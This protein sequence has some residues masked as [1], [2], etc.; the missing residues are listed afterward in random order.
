MGWLL[1][2]GGEF[3][4][5]LANKLLERVLLQGDMLDS[6]EGKVFTLIWKSPALS[7]VVAFP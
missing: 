1:E 6:L 5:K 4:V 2:G 3:L 7:K